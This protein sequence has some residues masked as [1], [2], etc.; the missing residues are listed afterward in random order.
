MDP[1]VMT[2]GGSAATKAASSGSG[3]NEGSSRNQYPVP[4]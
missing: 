3:S 4:T 1:K 2:T